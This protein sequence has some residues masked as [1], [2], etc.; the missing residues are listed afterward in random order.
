MAVG[1][2]RLA[3]GVGRPGDRAER[4]GVDHV[5]EARPAGQPQ[6]SDEAEGEGEQRSDDAEATSA[7]PA[8]AESRSPLEQHR[9]ALVAAPR[10]PDETRQASTTGTGSSS[11]S[12]TS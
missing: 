4:Q 7:P 1:H 6:R 2:H 8:G 9:A 5:V 10:S 3:G 11:H 12:L